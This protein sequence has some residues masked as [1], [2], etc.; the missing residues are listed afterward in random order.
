MNKLFAALSA[1]GLAACDHPGFG[2]HVVVAPELSNDQA[3]AAITLTIG[4][5]LVIYGRRR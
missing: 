5:M 2:G 4:I 1:L 3:A